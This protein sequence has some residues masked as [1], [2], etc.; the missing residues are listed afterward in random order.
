MGA[1]TILGGLFTFRSNRPVQIVLIVAG[2][3]YLLWSFSHLIPSRLKPSRSR[4][5]RRVYRERLRMPTEVLV[6]IVIMITLACGSMLGH[7]NTLLLVFSLMAGPFILNGWIVYAM[8]RR[9]EVNR[10]CPPSAGAGETFSVHITLRNKRRFL[11]CRLMRIEDTLS[12]KLEELKGRVLFFRIPVQESR[13]T[14]YRVRL[15]QRGIYTLGPTLVSSRFPFGLGER[16]RYFETPDEILIHPQIGELS[17]ACW[18]RVLGDDRP[19][20]E[21]RARSGVFDDDFNQIREYR[22][23]DPVRN[24]HWRTSARMNDLMVREFQENREHDAIILVELWQAPDTAE[25]DLRTELAASFA[26]TVCHQFAKTTH[27]SNV[28]FFLTGD[29][30]VAIVGKSSPDTWTQILNALARCSASPNAD[31][32]WL[33]QQA[34]EVRTKDQSPI[35]V[36]TRGPDDFDGSTR[37]R[38][39]LVHATEATLK[40]I[41][42]L[43]NDTPADLRPATATPT[44]VPV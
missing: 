9:V 36:T 16:G 41:F 6:Y 38:G 31:A 43:E 32:S 22:P 3:A 7:S 1:I 4:A 29:T 40:E 25:S 19:A 26:A 34:A 18:R 15:M 12:N 20:L 10:E 37:P 8:L 27:N 24:I 39:H 21:H 2:A 42:R 30:N 33:A 23:G 44:E 35:V 28:A 14:S 13:T 5:L 17:P 11:S